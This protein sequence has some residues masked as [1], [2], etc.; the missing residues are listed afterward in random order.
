M[1]RTRTLAELRAEVRARADIENDPHVT[2]AEV[3]RFINQSIAALHGLTVQACEGDFISSTTIPTVAGTFQYT[4]PTAF[5]KL[6]SVEVTANGR[7]RMI[8]KWTWPERAIYQDTATWNGLTAPLSY[9]LIG[10]DA[11]YFAPTPD[12][13]YSVKVWYVV[14]AQ[15]LSNDADVFDGR[16]GW[17]EWVVLDAAIKAKTK[18]EESVTDLVR[19]RAEVMAR[20]LPQMA[21][22]DQARPDSVVEV[23]GR[24]GPESYGI[25][26]FRGW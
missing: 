14:C 12:G 7:T 6:V 2:D 9:R 24:V 11:I 22:K 5:Y 10:S 8:D 4:L 15:Q 18:S 26:P 19:E 1:A 13:V 20:I 21:T 25:W 3:D 23:V 17:E 16:D